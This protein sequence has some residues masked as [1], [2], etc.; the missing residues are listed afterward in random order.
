MDKKADWE[1][2][3]YS[4]KGIEMTSK[5]DLERI[6]MLTIEKV[7]MKSSLE[8]A[9]L[10]GEVREWIDAKLTACQEKQSRRRRFGLSTIISVCSVLVALSAIIISLVRP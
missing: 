3:E 2:S 5:D 9:H 10:R 6:I 1:L 4:M 7:D 8:M